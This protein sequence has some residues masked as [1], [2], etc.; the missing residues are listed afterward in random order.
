MAERRMF[1][2]SV[3]DSDLF[4]DMP[5]ST[6]MLYF[7]LA[8]R[9]DDD[10]FVNNPKRIQRMVGASEDDMK[11]LIAKRFILV[12][13]SGVIVIRHWKL[14][15]YIRKD[16]YHPTDYQEKRNMLKFESM[17]SAYELNDSKTSQPSLQSSNNSVTDSSQERDDNVTD[18]S[19]DCNQSVS[20][21]KVRLD[22]TTTDDEQKFAEVVRIF[23]D[24]LHRPLT[25]M[26]ERESLIEDYDKYGKEWLEAAIKEAALSSN[27]FVNIKYIESI[28]K[29]WERE[30]FK[31]ERKKGAISNGGTGKSRRAGERG[32]VE[33]QAPDS[34]NEYD[35]WQKRQEQHRPWDTASDGSGEGTESGSDSQD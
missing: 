2:K 23:E 15:N 7:H 4:L 10:G 12:F 8:M 29:R 19:Q 16:M 5:S 18:S 22:T 28:L 20:I 6:Q 24:G 31:S 3:I 25:G 32:T 27:G 9:T 17:K 33:V 1:A 14:H 13:E 35:E 30:G 11:R 21:G 34:W 26:F